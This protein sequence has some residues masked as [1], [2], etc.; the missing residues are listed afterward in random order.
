MTVT[1]LATQNI[2]NLPIGPTLNCELG[3]QIDG[4]WPLEVGLQ[5]TRGQQAQAS[6]RIQLKYKLA[7]TPT[8]PEVQPEA[9]RV[10]YHFYKVV[11]LN[12]IKPTQSEWK[13]STPPSLVL[14]SSYPIFMKAPRYSLAP[15]GER[16]PPSS[17]KEPS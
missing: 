3:P 12:T 4:I 5:W 9:H 2:D 16:G 10:Q 6:A 14:S 11:P 13:L 15:T 7:L 17:Q 1:F 8:N